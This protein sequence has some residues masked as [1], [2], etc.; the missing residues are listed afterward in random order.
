MLQEKLDQPVSAPPSPRDMPMDGDMAGNLAQH[1]QYMRGEV[2]KLRNQLFAAQAERKYPV[3]VSDKWIKEKSIAE[4]C[5]KAL[6]LK[7]CR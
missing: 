7:K 1:I 5:N 2:T 3:A 4:T 6:R